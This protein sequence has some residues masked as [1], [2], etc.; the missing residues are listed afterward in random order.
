[1]TDEEQPPMSTD[2]VLTPEGL[3][4]TGGLPGAESVSVMT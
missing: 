1:M 2:A 4:P 3:V